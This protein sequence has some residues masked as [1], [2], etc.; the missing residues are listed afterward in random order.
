MMRTRTSARATRRSSPTTT[1]PGCRPGSELLR[2]LVGQDTADHDRPDPSWCDLLAKGEAETL[3]L[4]R[5]GGDAGGFHDDA[6]S[7][8]TASMNALQDADQHEVRHHRRAAH[9]HEWERNACHRRNAHRH[10]D[11]DEDLEEERDHQPASGDDAVE[12]ARPGDDAETAPHDEEVEKEQDRASDEAPLLSQRREGEVG[13]M[14]G[15][16]VESGL[17]RADHAAPRQPSGSDCRDRLAEV[18]GDPAGIGVGIESQ[19]GS[20]V[21]LEHLD[22]GCRQQ[23]EHGGDPDHAD[24]EQR[25]QLPPAKACEEQH[26][27][28]RRRVDERRSEVRLREDEKDR[29]GA[30]PDG[31][32]DRP[33]AGHRTS[34]VDD[35]AGDREHEE[36]LPELGRLELDEPEIEPPLRAA[37]RLRRDENDDHQPERHHVDDLP[38]P[39]PEVDGHDRGDHEPDRSDRRRDALAH[40]EVVLDTGNV[41]ARDPGDD[42]EAVPD[43]AGGREHEDPVQAAQERQDSGLRA[44]RPGAHA[45]AL[46]DLDHRRVST[47][48]PYPPEKPAGASTPKNRSNTLS[49]AGAAALEPCPPFSINAHTTSRADSDGPQP[50]HHD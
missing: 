1:A 17:A 13:R 37:D 23:P 21:R 34:A 32:E 28:E 7:K 45:R 39:A 8:L 44:P 41:E 43:E 26:R 35:E 3:H 38:V 50:H 31:R 42:P 10:T 19:A 30:Q 24:R 6:S 29:D 4:P 49:A 20:L 40:D 27:E 5:E 9:G 48:S 36:H 25:E 16:I 18:V 11:V 12:I 22:T 15:E 47:I 14:L 2:E 33:P 46:R